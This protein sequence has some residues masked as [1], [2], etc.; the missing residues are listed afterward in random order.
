[1]EKED[2]AELLLKKPFQK[3]KTP[4]PRDK[5]TWAAPKGPL[6]LEVGCGQGLH[7]ILF[8][9]DNPATHI[10][11]CERTVDKF[12]KFQSRLHSHNLSNITAIHEDALAWLVHNEENT[13]ERFE[14]IF[15]LYPNPYPKSTHRKKR[16]FSMPSFCAYLRALKVGGE[17]FLRTNEKFYVEEALFFSK[18]V[19]NLKLVYNGEVR[20]PTGITHFERKYLKRGEKC[21]EVVW[22]KV[23]A[24][25]P[26]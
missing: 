21:F 19:W 18:F 3:E 4:P 17:I 12:K 22:K 9:K 15:F 10:V 6:V 8:A 20:E 24:F 26:S 25:E 16:F 13:T 1:M 2:Y 14:K 11:A 7:P 23:K 5:S